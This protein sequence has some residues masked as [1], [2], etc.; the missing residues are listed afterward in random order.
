MVK[1]EFAG[2]FSK[3]ETLCSTYGYL[4][5]KDEI[6]KIRNFFI[7]RHFFEASKNCVV[8]VKIFAVA[9]ASRL[10]SL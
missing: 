4:E 2:N 1:I 8:S 5:F 6:L 7:L 9:S 3:I 10:S